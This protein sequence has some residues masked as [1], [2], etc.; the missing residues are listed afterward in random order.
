MNNKV[1][2][3]QNYILWILLY[4]ARDAIL[5]VRDNELNK[6]GLTVAEFST[7]HVI[8]IIGDEVTP[9]M[10]SKCMLRQHHSVTALLKRME[11]KWLI[12]MTK[13]IKRKNTWIVS[14]TEKGKESFRK[15]YTRDSLTSVMSVL[16]EDEKSRLVEYLT[17]LRDKAIRYSTTLQVQLPPFPEYFKPENSD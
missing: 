9:A 12:S 4:Q 3:D 14:L 11:K 8:N 5:K 7:L 1:Y 10:I 17:K 13:N 2:T 6:Y 15:S 16:M